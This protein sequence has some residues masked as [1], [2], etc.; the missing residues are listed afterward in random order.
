ME[1]GLNYFEKLKQWFVK[2][3]A[4]SILVVIDT[5]FICQN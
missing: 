1:I 5:M 4:N 2:R 3:L